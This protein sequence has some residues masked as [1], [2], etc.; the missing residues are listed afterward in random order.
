MPRVKKS[1]YT[2]NTQKPPKKGSTSLS[3]G[4]GK[5][6]QHSHQP[7]EIDPELLK[8]YG[9]V[10]SSERKE[11]RFKLSNN[12]VYVVIS[13]TGYRQDG[14]PKSR[15]I[16][17]VVRDIPI[18]KNENGKFVVFPVIKLSE[19]FTGDIFDVCQALDC[20]V[21]EFFPCV[22]RFCRYRKQPIE[23]CEEAPDKPKLVK[24]LHVPTAG[25]V[26]IYR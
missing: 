21:D 16:H 5:Y 2:G 12:V 22:S 20:A 11:F 23:Q 7:G 3:Q 17:R 4:V 14:V 19:K 10:H 26:K 24:V 6:R 1:F 18:G 15:S 25:K 9:V 8:S 13:Q